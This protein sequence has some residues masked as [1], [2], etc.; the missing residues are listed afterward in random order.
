MALAAS[1]RSMSLAMLSDWRKEGLLPPFASSGRG[2]GKGKSYFWRETDIGLRARLAYDLV[3]QYGRNDSVILILWLSGFSVSVP[4]FRRAWLHKVRSRKPWL[5]KSPTQTLVRKDVQFDYSAK[6]GASKR[7][8]EITPNSGLLTAILAVCDILV[9]DRGDSE[10]IILNNV[11]GQV[12]KRIAGKRARSGPDVGRLRSV[13]VRVVCSV[14]ESSN[15]ISVATEGEMLEAQHYL[16][17]AA[18][19]VQ[20]CKVDGTKS[21]VFTGREGFWSPEYA[22]VVGM[23][24][25]LF[26]VMLIRS[27]Y[28]HELHLTGIELEKLRKYWASTSLPQRS[29][30]GSKAAME[31]KLL[32]KSRLCLESIWSPLLQALA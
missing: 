27:G 15:L 7:R 17:L 2:Q 12:W 22:E 1:G 32:R 3:Q 28:Q 19:F 14:V 25:F 26:I 18:L 8:I 13:L 6:R 16:I 4:Q 21:V 9:P 11:T 23:P 5:S 20:S 10:I 31:E 30:R 24:L 29:G